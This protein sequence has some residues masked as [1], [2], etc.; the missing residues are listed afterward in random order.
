MYQGVLGRLHEGGVEAH[1]TNQNLFSFGQPGRGRETDSQGERQT[2]SAV[3]LALAA[4]RGRYDLFLRF[5]C[6]VL[7]PDCHGER[8]QGF[9]FGRR[10]PP[11]AGLGA[12]RRL[13][14]ESVR[15]AEER[16]RDRLDN[17]RECLREMSQ[18]DE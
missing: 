8:L 2:D 6:G 5:L 15:T 1:S 4:P 7:S 10:A 9:L 18:Q 14:E 12:A 16:H 13:L 17:L 3:A 11:V